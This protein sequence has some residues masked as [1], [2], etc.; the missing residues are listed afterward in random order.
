MELIPK[1]LTVDVMLNI[2]RTNQSICIHLKGSKESPLGY[3]YIGYS[4]HDDSFMIL[5]YQNYQTVEMKHKKLS[6]MPQ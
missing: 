5:K 1:V 3:S 2:L 4:D 6:F